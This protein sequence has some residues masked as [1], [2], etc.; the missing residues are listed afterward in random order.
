M[1]DDASIVTID[2]IWHICLDACVVHVHISATVWLIAW[3]MH[4]LIWQAD[5]ELS[6][7]H[8]SSVLMTMIHSMRDHL[9][10]TTV[11]LASA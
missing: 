7:I 8:A 4:G 9:L 3:L 2:I 6:E 1:H 11:K 5:V 10:A